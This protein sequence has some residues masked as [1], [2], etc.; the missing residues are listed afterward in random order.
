M[1]SHGITRFHDRTGRDLPAGPTILIIAGLFAV[2]HGHFPAL[3]P[4]GLVFGLVAGW[5]RHRTGSIVPGLVAHVLTDTL[6]FVLARLT[7]SR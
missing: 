1:G 7:V 2:E 6:L 5:L 4:V 3:L